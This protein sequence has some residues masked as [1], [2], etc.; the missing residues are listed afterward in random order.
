MSACAMP[1]CLKIGMDPA[2]LHVGPVALYWYGLMI[3]V[4]FMVAIRLAMT[5]ASREGLDAD[6]LLSAILVAALFGLVGARLYFILETQPGYYLAHLDQ[7]LSLWQGGLSF[8][9]GIFGAV[10]GAWL[11]CSRYNLPTLRYLDLGAL[12]APVGQAIGRIGN[13]INGDVSGYLTHSFGV[14]YTNPR[15]PL[16]PPTRLFHPSQ[17]VAI[18]EGLLDLLLFAALWGYA[19]NRRLNPGQLTGLY[20]AG[21]SVIQLVVYAFRDAPALSFG[22]KE[23]QLTALP[24]VAAGLWLF[25][26]ATPDEVVATDPV[27]AEDPPAAPGAGIAGDDEEAHHQ[28]EIPAEWAPTVIAPPPDPPPDPQIETGPDR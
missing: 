5:R 28:T 20:L 6:Q 2:L 15:N 24:V 22:L 11:Y 17:P 10:V 27:H 21:F 16:V 19:R 1:R 18:Y 12:V 9:G 23:G 7:A 25:L 26:R 3:A 8:Y 4:G 14:A 13:V